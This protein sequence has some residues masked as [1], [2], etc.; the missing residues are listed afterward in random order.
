MTSP[1]WGKSAGTGPESGHAGSSFFFGEIM[2]RSRVRRL[3]RTLRN[4]KISWTTEGGVEA[5][6]SC[7]ACTRGEARAN[8][9]RLFVETGKIPVDAIIV[10]LGAVVSF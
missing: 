3:P 10:C 5:C 1:K 7:Q 6:W 9:K 8:F 4:W 2:P